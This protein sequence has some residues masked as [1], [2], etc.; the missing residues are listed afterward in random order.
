MNSPF[1]PSASDLRKRVTFLL[2]NLWGGHQR[3]MASEVGIS[4]AT[5]SQI[6]LGNRDVGKR[7]LAV[8]ASHPAVNKEWL[9]TGKGEPSVQKTADSLPISS[10]LLPSP[11]EVASLT[12]VERHPV[13]TAFAKATRYWLALA[14]NSPLLAERTLRL[15][16]GDLLLIEADLDW[17]SRSDSC[18]GRICGIRL[19]S[20]NGLDFA[21]GLLV[22][23]D[24][25]VTLRFSDRPP[26]PMI[27]NP[28]DRSSRPPQVVNERP[29]RRTIRP[30]DQDVQK[31]AARKKADE[32]ALEM[33]AGI[34]CA[35]SDIVGVCVYIVR[36]MPIRFDSD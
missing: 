17:V 11:R 28:L 18:L 16:A 12:F 2:H 25:G 7:V 33:A 4:Q 23:R 26:S 8:L 6:V 24:G 34:P 20:S 13:A 21:L 5:I 35:L 31:A 29:M 3:K 22:E 19:T 36:P 10:R 9:L 30:I 14:D 1:P 32:R 27:F 15:A